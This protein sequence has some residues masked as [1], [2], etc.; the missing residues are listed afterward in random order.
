MRTLKGL[1]IGV[2]LLCVF[3]TVPAHATI[4]W[5]DGFEYANDAALGA[6]WSYSCLG[7]PGVSTERPHSGSKSLKLVYRGK[8]GVDPGA[9][10]CFI[11]R[12]LTAA[13]DTAYF[14][15]WTWQENFQADSVGTKMIQFAQNST[16]PNFWWEMALSNEAMMMAVTSSS[17]PGSS[18]I[19]ASVTIPQNQWVCLEGRITMNTP[20]VANGIIQSWV[21]G[22][23]SINRTD[24]LLRNAT[25]ANFNGP[26]S[27]MAFTR[28]YVQHGVGTIYYDDYA[29]S[30]DA[31]I[32]CTESPL[33]DR[34]A[35]RAPSGFS[36]R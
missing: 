2:T 22:T 35:P 7:N 18:N 17:P 10:G 20:G 6:V 12:S 3:W 33:G 32:G 9:G 25:L 29:V 4:D 28:L 23:Q 27:R 34:Q 1:T 16:Y 24:V 13:S 5:E 30:R 15:M 21:N 8:V 36:F 19:F 14:R 11:D 26:N 31:R